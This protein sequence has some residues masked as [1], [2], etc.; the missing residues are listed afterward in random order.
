MPSLAS[1]F[2]PVRP[3]FGSFARDTKSG[4]LAGF[5]AAEADA[6]VAGGRAGRKYGK[7]VADEAGKE[8][9]GGIGRQARETG[10]LIAGAFA[11]E[12]VVEF[13]GDSIKAASDLN[14]AGNKLQVTFGSAT[15]NV[16]QW[17]QGAA[18]SFGLSTLAAEDAATTFGV[19]AKSAGLGGQAAAGFSEQMG[20]LAGDLASFY[21][22]SPEQAID[23]IGA[24]LRGE[25]EPI[26]QYGVLLDDATLRQQALA[27]GLISTTKTAL[28]PQQRVLAAQ[29]AILKQTTAAQGDFARTSGGLANQQRILA[30]EMENVKGTVGQALLPIM[31]EMVSLVRD[32]GIPVLDTFGKIMGGIPPSA[33]A[34]AAGV[35]G[36]VVAVRA[37][38]KAFDAAS[39]A[40]KTVGDVI[41]W[42]GRSSETA[43]VAQNAEAAAATRQATANQAAAVAAGEQA[44]AS[45]RQAGANDAA[46]ASAARMGTA[47]GTA[48]GRLTVAAGAIGIVF[49]TIKLGEWLS[50]LNAATVSTDKLA[51]SMTRAGAV[52]GSTEFRHLFDRAGIGNFTID[53]QDATE[54]MHQFANEASDAFGQG[55]YQSGQRFL[56][57]GLSAH[58][59]DADLAKL[60]DTLVGM[61]RGG[62]AAAAAAMF[63]QLQ[64]ELQKAGY[65]T[66]FINRVL[67]KYSQVAQEASRASAAYAAA[68]AQADAAQRAALPAAQRTYST[69]RGATV[70][71]VAYS[72]QMG[73]GANV[74]RSV[75]GPATAAHTQALGANTAAG[76]AAAQV[77]G[78]V[79]STVSGLATALHAQVIPAHQEQARKLVNVQDA[80]YAAYLKERLLADANRDGAT[81]TK[82]WNKYLDDQYKKLQTLSDATIGQWQADIGLKG[83][84]ADL[85]QSIKENGRTLDLNTA[86]GRANAG[87]LQNVA[88]QTRDNLKAHRDAGEPMRQFSQRVADSTKRLEDEAVKAGM[89]RSAARKYA[90]AIL[91]VPRK[92]VT[93][94]VAQNIAKARAQAQALKADLDKLRGVQTITLRANTDGSFTK[95]WMTAAGGTRSTTLR[96]HGGPIPGHS[97]T[98]T[99]DN[100]PLMATAGEHMWSVAEVNAAGGHKAVANLRAAALSGTL[101]ALATGGPVYRTARQNYQ[102]NM[103]S[104]V[105]ANF[106]K[107]LN[108]VANYVGKGYFAEAGPSVNM[109][110]GGVQRWLPM[111]RQALSIAGQP[112][113]LAATTLRRMNQESGGSPTA[114]NRWDINW[115]RGT[116]SVGLLQVIGPTYA[117]WHHP[118]YNRGPFAYGVSEDPL[119][120]TLASMRYAIGNYGSL[121]RAYNR[122]GGYDG[123]GWVAPGQAAR[124]TTGQPERMLDPQESRSY[125]AAKAGGGRGAMVVHVYLDGARVIDDR[126][127]VVVED[128]LDAAGS[129]FD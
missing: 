72:A 50:G 113:S 87:V 76:R 35:G 20:G 125:A 38:T 66:T 4:L 29:A 55:L 89:S 39:S 37:G 22:T 80:A 2:V 44:A 127:R 48:V 84:Q 90:D 13:F 110:G 27:M 112:Q 5:N 49:G 43:A 95:V 69:T 77:M 64:G 88:S 6:T 33:F 116:P 85:T 99:A 11:V 97:P 105:S 104:S 115:Q 103:T 81:T 61:A 46:A 120:N 14:E 111:V 53:T 62:N 15:G 10:E 57:F 40:A 58:E 122:A 31:L 41:L 32:Y 83:A 47:F 17:A 67:P 79:S 98:P 45:V 21:N 42:L 119:S 7:R 23:A 26:R 114:I 63:A 102:P 73:I 123:G 126:I 59:A 18:T 117:R 94:Y 60:D 118:A 108:T 96:A 78:R 16:T 28:T 75:A 86:K 129:Q 56:S 106:T 100:V 91:G 25:S 3:E 65:S 24:A 121:A 70:A 52:G 8:M 1:V 12:K 74:L 19:F 54:A 68:V 101:Q 34:L 71:T 36:A 82:E 124:N 93:E 30:A 107:A 109:P 92:Q 128:G 9:K 51:E